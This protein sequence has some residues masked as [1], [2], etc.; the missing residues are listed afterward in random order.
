[1]AVLTDRDRERIDF[2][3]FLLEFQLKL[4]SL[5]TTKPQRSSDFRWHIHASQGTKE[6]IAQL[7]CN[8]GPHLREQRRQRY[9]TRFE[10]NA[11]DVKTAVR[12]REDAHMELYRDTGREGKRIGQAHS[13]L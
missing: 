12:T 13:R 2:G 8:R 4:G 6:L 11:V 3:D 9:D 10:R 5:L 1:L 7:V